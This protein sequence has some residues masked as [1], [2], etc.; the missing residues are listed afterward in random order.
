MEQPLNNDL[1]TR[2]ASSG[3]AE[4]LTPLSSNASVILKSAGSKVA[5]DTT[6]A[7]KAADGIA[8]LILSL[9]GAGSTGRLDEKNCPNATG[10]QQKSVARR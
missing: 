5:C 2:G 4:T 1:S 8:Y 10:M 7:T 3:I 6:P 9:G